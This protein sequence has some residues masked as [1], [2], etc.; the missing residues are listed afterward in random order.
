M[1][2]FITSFHFVDQIKDH[3]N[4]EYQDWDSD[5]VRQ[6]HILCG[7]LN[8]QVRLSPP[9]PRDL[10]TGH[11]FERTLD[12]VRLDVEED[13]GARSEDIFRGSLHKNWT[14]LL[15]TQYLIFNLF[16]RFWLLEFIHN[17]YQN[18]DHYHASDLQYQFTQNHHFVDEKV[19]FEE[20]GGNQTLEAVR[21]LFRNWPYSSQR[22]YYALY[23]DRTII[24]NLQ[25]QREV[26]EEV[27]ENLDVGGGLC[28]ELYLDLEE[29]PEYFLSNNC[30][31]SLLEP[32]DGEFD[33][34]TNK[35]G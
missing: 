24:Q 6:S 16:S 26:D 14:P 25:D 8:V 30:I 7:A 33:H 29:H 18:W 4:L 9:L 2:L 31:S 35:Q 5:P 19:A 28:F 22:I 10:S 34:E 17:E 15:P 13:V 1:A 32:G 20:G 23:P 11:Q 21:K 12:Q 3:S 27:G